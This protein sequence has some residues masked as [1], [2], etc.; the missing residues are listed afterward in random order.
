MH[1]ATGLN[2]HHIKLF[3]REL[4]LFNLLSSINSEL[5]IKSTY[6]LSSI[7]IVVSKIKFYEHTTFS[8]G[9]FVLAKLVFEWKA[10]TWYL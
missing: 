9:Q 4:C 8:V 1:S 2:E 5:I 7:N 3:Q 10:L 6:H